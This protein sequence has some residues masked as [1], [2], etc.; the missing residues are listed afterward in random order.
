MLFSMTHSENPF[1]LD[2]NIISR[3][4]HN[5]SKVY[6]DDFTNLKRRWRCRSDPQF[7]RYFP[8]KAFIQFSTKAGARMGPLTVIANRSSRGV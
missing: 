3:K 7:C 1:Y 6:P 8:H 4:H 2:D 5:T